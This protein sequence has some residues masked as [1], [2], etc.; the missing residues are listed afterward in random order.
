MEI[1]TEVNKVFGQEMA[2]LFAQ[3]ISEEE[4]QAKATQI[5]REMNTTPTWGYRKEPEIVVLIKDAIVGRIYK[6]IEEILKEPVAEEFLEN[7][8]REMVA[9]ARKVGEEAIIKDMAR[10]MVN[11]TLSVWGRDEEIIMEVMRTL[12]VE[13]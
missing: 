10:H 13:K 3:T 4:I 9:A 2:K 12:K 11:N 5:W 1:T 8:A 7:K 6:K